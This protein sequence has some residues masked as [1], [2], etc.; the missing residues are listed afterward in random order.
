MT[1]KTFLMASALAAT[2]GTAHA[3][4]GYTLSSASS[5]SFQVLAD[6]SGYLSG[7]VSSAYVPGTGYDITSVTVGGTSFSDVVGYGADVF[8][9]SIPI[10][11][12]QTYDILVQGMSY[13]G[14]GYM[15]VW[16]TTPT[17]DEPGA[18]LLGLAGLVVVGLL[19]RR[20]MS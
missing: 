19:M 2:M 20:R 1:M 11:A 9:F 14:L 16:E 7:S 4:P 13:K 12:G 17:V 18:Y 6:V 10:I 15:A 3:D 5:A 8:S